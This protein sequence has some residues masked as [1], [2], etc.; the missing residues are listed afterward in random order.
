MFEMGRASGLP[1]SLDIYE[2]VMLPGH[3]AYLETLLPPVKG[4]SN[5]GSLSMFSFSSL[6]GPFVAYFIGT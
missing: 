1:T 5:T 4:I 2:I 3:L 6:S